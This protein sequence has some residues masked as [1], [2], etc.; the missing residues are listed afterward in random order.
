MAI[1]REAEGPESRKLR[2]ETLVRLRWLA[3]A[4]QAATVAVV[5]FFLQFSLPVEIAGLRARRRTHRQP[6]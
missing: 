3:V 2:L 4:G 6:R 5:G 1:E